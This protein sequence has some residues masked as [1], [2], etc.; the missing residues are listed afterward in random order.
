MTERQKE[1]IE[2]VRLAL[3]RCEQEGLEFGM[4]NINNKAT[5][6]FYDPSH[7]SDQATLVA[8]NHA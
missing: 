6:V 1:A 7:G 5:F 4:A 8:D 3:M 2:A